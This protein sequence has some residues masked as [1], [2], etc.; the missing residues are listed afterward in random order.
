MSI[1]TWF[2]GLG[3]SY[4]MGAAVFAF[5]AASYSTLFYLGRKWR[6]RLE[7]EGRGY[8]QAPK[9]ERINELM[10]DYWQP[11][12]T[13]LLY[14]LAYFSNG[15]VRTTF[16]L[17]VPIYLLDEAGVSVS[18]ASLFVGLMYV[19]WSWKTFVGLIAD[20]FPLKWR[21]RLYKRKPWFLVT[22]LLY[23]AGLTVMATRDMGN[24]PVWSGLFP[25][26]TSVISAGAFYDMAADSFA[27]DVTPPEY[28]ARV[29]GAVSTSSQ[30]LGSALATIIPLWL[31]EVGGYKAVFTLASATGLTCF[32]YLLAK[33]PPVAGE[34]RISREAVAFTFTEPAVVL[35]SLLMF[36]RAFTVNKITAPLGGM[37]S[38]T[39]REVLGGEVSQV[40]TLGLV[41]TLAGIPG[42][43][44]GGKLSDQMGHKRAFLV[45][46]LAFAG[47]GLL[48]TTIAPGAVVWFTL[49]AMLSAF[50]ERFWT[51]TVF[52]IMAD[53]TPLA[54]SSTVYQMYMSWSW[55]GNIP[56]SVMI[57]WLLGRGLGTTALVTSLL[58]ALPLALGLLI[59]PFEAGK[60]S[61]I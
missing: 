43:W 52:A 27:I 11:R 22:G 13:S 30:S 24:L 48:W 17:W 18:E 6:R 45:S 38:F 44:L 16:S 10:A 51:S 2:Q 60:A 9:E 34:R 46:S 47:A 8:W 33:E 15:F 36:F 28:H 58:M 35:A 54:M 31:L 25:A 39:I 57:G 5:T 42:S 49:V 53:S 26:V 19:S 61:K 21:G 1:L 40:S 20:L 14:G 23:L 59:K 29:I 37:F 4:K 7:E 12:L 32:L 55:I 56:S 50:L 41:A 3:L